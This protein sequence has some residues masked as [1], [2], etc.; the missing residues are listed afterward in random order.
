MKQGKVICTRS[1]RK[2]GRL[3]SQFRRIYDFSYCNK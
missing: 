3:S 2:F 1:W